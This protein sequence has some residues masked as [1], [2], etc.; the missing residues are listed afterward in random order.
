M[1]FLKEKKK[2][3][4]GCVVV[5]IPLITYLLWLLFFF[6]PVCCRTKTKVSFDN[7]TGAKYS[8]QEVSPAEVFMAAVRTLQ[9]IPFQC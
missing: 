2:I 4:L 1:H 8:K 9:K 6:T 5:F 7:S 3:S